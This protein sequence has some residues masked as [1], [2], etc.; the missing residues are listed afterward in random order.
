M[1]RDVERDH[2]DSSI[3]LPDSVTRRG[4]IRTA[5]GATLGGSALLNAACGS[6]G[7]ST[8]P[9]AGPAKRG[10]TLRLAITDAV[11]SE[12]LDPALSFAGNDIIYLGLIFESL[13]TTDTQWNLKPALA[14]SWQANDDA[15]Q[16][17]FKLRPGVKF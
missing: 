8:K 5:V 16:W 10:G 11:S 7:P 14:T 3:W 2:A 13:T 17:T 1:S 15:T 9:S 12:K 6:N 4:L